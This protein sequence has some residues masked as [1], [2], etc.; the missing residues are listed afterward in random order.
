[1]EWC[2]GIWILFEVKKVAVELVVNIRI[3]LLLAE[4]QTRDVHRCLKQQKWKNLLWSLHLQLGQF[5]ML[6]K[7]CIYLINNTVI[8]WNL[9]TVVNFQQ[10]L[11]QSL[12]SHDPSEFILICWFWSFDHLL[13]L[14]LFQTCMSFS[15]LLN[16]R[17]F[18]NVHNE[19]L[20]PIY[21]NCIFFHTVEANGSQQLFG[22][23]KISS[24]FN[25]RKKL[26]QVFNSL[27]L[28]KW[29]NWHFEVFG[30]N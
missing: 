30:V 25:D 23:S 16:R 29:Q 11:L 5:I 28:S 12:L 6:T 1:M 17:Y 10:T 24:V 18:E 22:Y 19:Q 27:R 21:F 8:L 14:K 15:L 2:I 4:I 3:V 20:V 9:I 26:V 7:S 13:T